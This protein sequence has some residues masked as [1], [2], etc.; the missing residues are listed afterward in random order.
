MELF[1]IRSEFQAK[2]KEIKRRLE[3]LRAN[4]EK[5][6]RKCRIVMDFEQFYESKQ[7]LDGRESYCIE[8]KKK[9]A[10]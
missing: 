8:C 2:R 5:L 4:G 10:A 6:C 7:R 1:Q 3:Q 9:K